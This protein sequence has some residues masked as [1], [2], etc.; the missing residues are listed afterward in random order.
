MRDKDSIDDDDWATTNE[1]TRIRNYVRILGLWMGTHTPSKGRQKHM[2]LSTYVCFCLHAYGQGL[3]WKC[4][5]CRV[6]KIFSKCR[7]EDMSA[8]VGTCRPDIHPCLSRTS[9][10]HSFHSRNHI[11]FCS[12]HFF[13]F[14]LKCDHKAKHCI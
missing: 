3:S 2:S 4:R 1:W 14:T 9:V 6:G 13:L 11:S 5:R 12:T 8:H 10:L 7:H